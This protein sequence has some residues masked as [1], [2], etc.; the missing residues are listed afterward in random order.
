M[1][2]HPLLLFSLFFS[3]LFQIRVKHMISQV[4]VEQSPLA[5]G[6]NRINVANP[7]RI[8]E[9]NTENILRM[10]LDMISPS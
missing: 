8:L 6:Y 10:V 2:L 4:V 7:G 3:I 1:S 5:S 9:T